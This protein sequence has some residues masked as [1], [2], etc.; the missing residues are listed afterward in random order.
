MKKQNKKNNY[1]IRIS[2][3]PL[4][5]SIQFANDINN[6]KFFQI[7]LIVHILVWSIIPLIIFIINIINK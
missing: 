2:K 3:H 7:V 6:N 4:Y 1:K 5:T